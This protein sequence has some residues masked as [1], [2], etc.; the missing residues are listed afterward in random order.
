MD[1]WCS[2]GWLVGQ[3]DS[4]KRVGLLACIRCML[5]LEQN[6]FQSTCTLYWCKKSP[7]VVAIVNFVWYLLASSTRTRN[8]CLKLQ[9]LIIYT[10]LNTTFYGSTVRKETCSLFSPKSAIGDSLFMQPHFDPRH[11]ICRVLSG[12]VFHATTRTN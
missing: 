5:T 1:V 2:T 11:V 7:R 12:R 8:Q 6:K 4:C 9:V 3:S 10:I